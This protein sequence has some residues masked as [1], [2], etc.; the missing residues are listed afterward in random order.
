MSYKY[1]SHS[2]FPLLTCWGSLVSACVQPTHL[3]VPAPKLLLCSCNGFCS[4]PSPPAPRVSSIAVGG[5]F[6][7]CGNCFLGHFKNTPSGYAFINGMFILKLEDHLSLYIKYILNIYYIKIYL[8]L[9]PGDMRLCTFMLNKESKSLFC[10]WKSSDNKDIFQDLEVHLSKWYQCCKG[11]WDT[12]AIWTSSS[13]ISL[14]PIHVTE[15]PDL[16]PDGS[17]LHRRNV[18]TPLPSGR[19]GT[20]LT[21]NFHPL[22]KTSLSPFSLHSLL[23]DGRNVSSWLTFPVFLWYVLSLPPLPTAGHWGASLTQMQPSCCPPHLSPSSS[24]SQDFTLPG[25]V[26]T[27][28]QNA[29]RCFDVSSL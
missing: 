13:G 9:S 15:P 1:F 21:F 19:W 27:V 10:T 5:P 2:N 12:L 18:D 11:H 22:S 28:V 17:R 29:Q 3:C 23:R 4:P 7:Q 8:L 14:L 20:P 16:R 26:G 6:A 25:R 24:N